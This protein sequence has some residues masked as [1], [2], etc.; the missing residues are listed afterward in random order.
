[1][2][3]DVEGRRLP[4]LNALKAFEAVARLSSITQAAKELNVTPGAVSQQIRLLEDHA[5]GPLMMR[6][7]GGLS[8]TDLG[9]RLRPVVR[10]AFDHLKLAADVIYGLSARQS[11]SVSVPPSFAVRWLVPRMSRFYA[12]HPEIETWIS[13]DMKLADVAGGRADVAVRYGQGDYPGVRSEVL[14]EAG[15]I[16]ICSPELLSGAHPLKT[17]AD[18]AHHSLIHVT[19]SQMEEPRPDW[20]AWLASRKLEGIDARLGARFDQTAFVIED[21]IHGR[22]V[23]LAPRAFVAQELAAGR[24]VAPFGDG[25]LATDNAYRLITRRGSLRPAAQAFV[26]W[27]RAEAAADGIVADEL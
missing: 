26:A 11:L 4:P 17:P 15:V 21:A 7:G 1:M 9:S 3:Q 10:E 19:P 22:G 18:L 16:P 27:L 13:A 20:L 8:L 25:Y 24:L 14:I 5:G 2:S 6:E 12:L 23:A